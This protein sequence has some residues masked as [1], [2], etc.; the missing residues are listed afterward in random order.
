[1]NIFIIAA[2]VH[3]AVG[4]DAGW[5]SYI[6]TSGKLPLDA[7]ILRIERV[8]V[9]I[10]ATEVDGAIGT[11]GNRVANRNSATKK[12]FEGAGFGYGDAGA[13]AGAGAAGIGGS[14][15]EAEHVADVEV[16]GD[17][18]AGVGAIG[19]VDVDAE[20]CGLLPEVGHYGV[21]VVLSRASE[22]SYGAY[23]LIVIDASVDCGWDVVK[24]GDDDAVAASVA[25]IVGYRELESEVGFGGDCGGGEGGLGYVGIAEIDIVAAAV[26]LLPGI[27]GDAAVAIGAGRAVE[28]DFVSFD[29]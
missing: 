27:R 20:A 14:E 11:D 10:K 8:E 25:C 4:A 1:M 9:V 18:E 24:Y 26:D 6:V 5:C 15:L 13:G 21:E 22:A 2:E 29:Y 17:D 3:G 12:P 16:C 7:A 28:L 19:S 23:R